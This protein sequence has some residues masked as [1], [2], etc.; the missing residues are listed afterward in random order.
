M[1][2]KEGLR[3]AAADEEFDHG[4]FEVAR[5]AIEHRTIL[6]TRDGA[7]ENYIL[8]ESHSRRR[9]VVFFRCNCC[10]FG[11]IIAGLH[12]DIGFDGRTASTDLDFWIG[13]WRACAGLVNMLLP[14]VSRPQ[15][16][17]PRRV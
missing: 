9:L 2:H 4:G 5:R 17:S 6:Q 7:E 13:H 15:G 3:I 8:D 1:R 11:I 10:S 12:V 14:G 16:G